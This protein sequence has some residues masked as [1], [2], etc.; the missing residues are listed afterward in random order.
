MA[1]IFSV[2]C[3]IYLLSTAMS[4]LS[5]HTVSPYLSAAA[6]AAS[7]RNDFRVKALHAELSHLTV[8]L[9]QFF[10]GRLIAGFSGVMLPCVVRPAVDQ[11]RPVLSHPAH[12][13]L[14]VVLEPIALHRRHHSVI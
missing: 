3:L 13:P 4:R 2:D 14:H 11:G 6:T 5:I 10:I 9:G 12:I 1:R 8:C 7:V